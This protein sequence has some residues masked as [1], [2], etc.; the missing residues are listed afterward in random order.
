MK[1]TSGLGACAQEPNPANLGSKGESIRVHSP[2]KVSQAALLALCLL[3]VRLW[4]IQ[5]V[6]CMLEGSEAHTPTLMRFPGAGWS[7]RPGVSE[8]MDG[9]ST[10]VGTSGL[11]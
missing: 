3:E 1:K 7:E 10:E 11:F 4:L 5:V 2:G 9:A 6:D 8:P